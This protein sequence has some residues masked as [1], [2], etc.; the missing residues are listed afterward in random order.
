MEWILCS[1][2]L[3]N[4]YLDSYLITIKMKYPHEMEWEYHVDVAI[5]SGM[6]GDTCYIDNYWN[7][8]NDW[9]EGQEIHVVAWMP[10]PKP[11]QE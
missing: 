9:D 4:E 5:N 10:L 6:I 2:R 1:E 7:T 8:F 11:Y 3:P